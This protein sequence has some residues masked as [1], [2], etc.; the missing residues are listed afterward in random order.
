MVIPPSAIDMQVAA[1]I[2]LGP[3][4]IGPQHAPGGGVLLQVGSSHPVQAYPSKGVIH[5]Q[6]GSC[7]GNA[8][9]L[10]AEL[11]RKMR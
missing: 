3:K 8:C 6:G 1:Q 11:R 9:A 10:H 5:S 7:G 4:T 2:P